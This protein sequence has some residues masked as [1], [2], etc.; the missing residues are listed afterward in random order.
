[1]ISSINAPPARCDQYIKFDLSSKNLGTTTAN[2]ILWFELDEN[3]DSVQIINLP[4]T[5]VGTDKYGWFFSDLFPSQSIAK[6]IRLK[7]PGVLDFPIG[8]ELH[9]KS[10]L[11]YEDMNGAQISAEFLY[12]PI[13]VCA[14]DPN[15]KLVNP[16][17]DGNYTLFEEQL[18]YTVRFQNTGNDVAYDVT[19]RDTLDANLDSSTFRLLGSSHDN[20]LT[21]TLKDGQFL[22]FAFKNIFLPDST[23]DFE[24]S[25][26]YVSYLIE[27]NENLPEQTPIQN[28][29][30]IYFD[31][32]P[33]IVTNTTENLMVSELP[34]TAIDPEAEASPFLIYPNPTS[35]QLQIINEQVSDASIEV[36]DYMGRLLKALPFHF[37]QN[38]NLV[39][40]PSGVYWIQ[41]N[42][43]NTTFS[44]KVIKF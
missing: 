9:F 23:S 10:Y 35:D 40:Y 28:T 32:N 37:Q 7:I 19:I 2:G 18:I 20:Q 15:D 4:D 8:D 44:E 33:P 13:V 25:Q 42:T 11:D 41:I 39:D 31:T 3:I 5:V 34:T 36:R 26:G 22:T 38:I 14:Y 24:G 16:A 1:M 29:A 6:S 30:S 27:G 17:R 21:A 43:D 12:D